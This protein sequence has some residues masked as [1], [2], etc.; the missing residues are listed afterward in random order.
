MRFGPTLNHG[1][2]DELGLQFYAK[3]R[4]FSFD[5]GYYNTHLRFGFTSSSVANNLL[6]LNR[7]NQ[8]R[9]PSPGGVLQAWQSGSVLQSAAVD[10]APTYC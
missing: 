2:S 8:M 3:G 1:Q 10:A 9:Q 7:Q 6:V 4:E 5:P